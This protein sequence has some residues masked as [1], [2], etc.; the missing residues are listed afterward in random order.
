MYSP[1]AK[2]SNRALDRLRALSLDMF[3]PV[4]TLDCIFHV[5]DPKVITTTYEDSSVLTN[6]DIVIT[7]KTAAA[8]VKFRSPQQTPE[9]QYDIAP[10]IPF[11]MRQI[12]GSVEF[13]KTSKPLSVPLKQHNKI[14]QSTYFCDDQDLELLFPIDDSGPGIVN[15]EAEGSATKRRKMDSSEQASAS[16]ATGARPSNT[17]AKVS[18]SS[19]GKK[20]DKE[21]NSKQR[22]RQGNKSMPET[23]Y[24]PSDNSKKGIDART[25]CAVYGMEMLSYAMGVH[26]AIVCLII[27]NKYLKPLFSFSH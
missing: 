14:R 25:Q 6:P 17:T 10:E 22:S 5:N 23:A 19:A 7:S 1:F 11:D 15:T 8:D 20:K 16:S 9:N 12:L 21:S 24:F 18:N 27:G 4:S 2:L 3:K 26:H 13:K